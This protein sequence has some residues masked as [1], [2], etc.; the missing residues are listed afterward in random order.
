MSKIKLVEREDCR[1]EADALFE[2]MESMG[3]SRKSDTI[4]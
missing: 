2:R 3:F 1:E 4:L